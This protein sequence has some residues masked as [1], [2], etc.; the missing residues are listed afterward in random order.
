M[1]KVAVT[2]ALFVLSPVAV[3]LAGGSALAGYGGSGGAVQGAV[4]KTGSTLPFTGMDLSIVA[5]IAIV[6]VASGLFLRRA[7]RP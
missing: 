2:V 7:S 4:Q 6:L 3:A 5:A 1:R